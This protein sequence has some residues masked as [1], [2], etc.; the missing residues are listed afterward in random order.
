M[1]IF[2]RDHHRSLYESSLA[3]AEDYQNNFSF[4]LLSRE[5]PGM[6]E[7]AVSNISSVWALKRCYE[8]SHRKVACAARVLIVYLSYPCASL[9]VR[10]Y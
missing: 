8:W 6:R 5:E 2:P 3:E 1:I 9:V 10:R 4:F 7:C